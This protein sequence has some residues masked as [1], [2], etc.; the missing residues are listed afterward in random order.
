MFWSLSSPLLHYL[1]TKPLNLSYILPFHY[2]YIVFEGEEGQDAGGLLREW[3]MIISRE[4]FNPMYALFRTSPGD[5][6][7]YTINPSS[8]CNPNHLSYFKFVGRVVAKAVYDN[9][10]LECYFTRSFYKHILGKSVRYLSYWLLQSS[11]P[12]VQD[13]FQP[14]DNPHKPSQFDCYTKCGINRSWL[15]IFCILFLDIRIN[16]CIS[17][18]SQIHRH[19]EWGLP[20]LPGLGLLVGEWCFH[21]GLWADV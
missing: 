4:M 11:N 7:T 17:C 16:V 3:Y 9:R 1:T 2:R 10:L 12:I 19:G 14:T 20:V 5:R 8:H 21:T 18:Y 13:M 6:V 15:P